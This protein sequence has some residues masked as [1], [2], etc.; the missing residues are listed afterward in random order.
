MSMTIETYHGYA[1]L[2]PGLDVK[3]ID[4]P[5]KPWTEK[6]VEIKITHCG[7]CGSD[8]HT[9]TGG[10]GKIQ[11]PQVVGHEIIGHVV[12]IGSQVDPVKYQVGPRVGVGAQCGSCSQCRYCSGK[13]E[14]LCD[15][16]IFTY[17][18]KDNG[19]TTQGGYANY[20]RCSSE[21]V[22]PIPQGLSSEVAAPLMCAGITTYAPLKRYNIGPNHQVAVIGIGGLGHL[23]IQWAVALGAQ[24]TAISSSDKKRELALKELGAHDYINSSD[25][26]Q[27]KGRKFDLVLCTAFGTDSD[28]T[29]LLS[30]VDKEGTFVMV[31]LPEKPMSLGAG[32]LIRSQVSLAG[33]IIGAPSMIEEML[34][35]AVKKN[36]KPIVEVMPMEK[37]AEAL[38]KMHNGGARFRIVL[39]NK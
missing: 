19:Y 4:Y 16:G 10:W 3:P 17:N 23:G 18:S 5:A 27:L 21:F 22:V 6:D 38:D 8:L 7:I 24:V 35:F 15:K 32:A 34:D 11:Y 37:A 25:P 12:R 33:S 26:E 13:K 14:N 36:V 2:E 30:L 28:W 31:A 9:I 1:A 39:E 29:T 20:Y